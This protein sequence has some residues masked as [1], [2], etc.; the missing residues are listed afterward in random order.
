[1]KRVIGNAFGEKAT[2][3]QAL[4][5]GLKREIVGGISSQSAE[6]M[7]A[8]FPTARG[9]TA[10]KLGKIMSAPVWLGRKVGTRMEE[11][12]RLAFFINRWKVGYNWDDAAKETFKYLFDYAPEAFKPWETKYAARIF[13]FYR[14][15][16]NNI[17][18]QAR[19]L[20]EGPNVQARALRSG[21]AK[22]QAYSETQGIPRQHL[23]EWMRRGIPVA[24]GKEGERASMI[25]SLGIPFEDLKRTFSSFNPT[26]WQ[27]LSQMSPLLK[28]PLERIADR[29]FYFGTPISEYRTAYNALRGLPDPVKKLIGLREIEDS[30]GKKRLEMNPYVL[31]LLQNFRLFT[32]AGKIGDIAKR[33]QEV[34][35]ELFTG[36]RISEMNLPYA[37]RQ[38]KQREIDKIVEGLEQTGEMRIF[39]QPYVPKG[40]PE[41]PAIKRVQRFLEE[42]R[43]RKTAA[44]KEK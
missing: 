25:T 14:W 20:L 21:I 8:V 37:E 44:K 26:D 5:E 16:R 32:T 12:S 31:H 42:E 13:P 29:N 43:K 4:R 34:I 10:G 22:L 9:A 6:I 17:A 33:P 24:L 28:Y 11:T 3:E 40:T 23:P 41:T 15:Q 30:Q 19:M 2:L 1:M 35:P 7:N 38:A 27:I 36:T 39:K 18:L